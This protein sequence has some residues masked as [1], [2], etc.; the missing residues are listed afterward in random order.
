MLIYNF[1]TL[2]SIV[3]TT[4]IYSLFLLQHICLDLIACTC[5]N[6]SPTRGLLLGC[7]VTFAYLSSFICP[8]TFL[9]CHRSKIYR[10]L[11]THLLRNCRR[12]GSDEGFLFS[13]LF[14]PCLE[15]EGIGDFLLE[16]FGSINRGYANESSALSVIARHS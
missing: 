12:S 16:M 7:R 4:T 5:W 6:R 3:A 8:V 1:C 14:I 10:T 13:C 11:P 9:E 15:E 2:D